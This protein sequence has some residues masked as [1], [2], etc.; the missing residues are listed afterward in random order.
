MTWSIAKD[1]PGN[2]VLA[3]KIN[4][5]EEKEVWLTRHDR[6][7][8]DLYGT[9]PLAE[10][11]PVMLTDHYDRNPAKQLLKGRIGY[12]KSWVLDDKE[13]SE[14]EGNVRYL[15]YPPKAVLVEVTEWVVENGKK[16]ERPCSWTLDGMTEPCRC[17][18]DQALEP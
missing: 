1:K 15:R 7:C 17:L 6:D 16:V 9:L 11:L 13:D 18:S 5:E 3:E 12:M 8:A 4:L 14:Y 2:R 10:G